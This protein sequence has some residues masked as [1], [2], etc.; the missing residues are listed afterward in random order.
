MK[1][2]QLQ[3]LE[4][5]VIVIVL[6]LIAA[7]VLMLFVK[8]NDTSPSFD[9][10][11]ALNVLQRVST[12]P[13]LSC[14]A[15]ETAGTHC[16]DLGKARAFS[17]TVDE[18]FYQP[19]FGFTSITL[20]VVEENKLEEILLYDAT[21]PDANVRASTTYFTVHDPVTDTR[22]FAMLTIRREVG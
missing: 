1:K 3:T 8:L 6:V 11:E 7:I 10:R 22:K 12:M 19:V 2:G 17:R 9:S 16:I 20:E 14:P 18:I 15:I 13:E 4:P 21:V 5:I